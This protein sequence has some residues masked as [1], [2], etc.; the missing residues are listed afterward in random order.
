VKSQGKDTETIAAISTPP[1][2]GAIAVVRVSGERALDIARTLFLPASGENPTTITRGLSVGAIRDPLRERTLD[3]AVMLVFTAPASYTGEDMVEFHC[4][5]GR[6]TPGLVM[7][8]II[9][10]GCREA[11][12]GEFTLRAYLNGKLD[13][14]QAESVADL[15]ESTNELSQRA[16]VLS[17]EGSL[18]RVID[19]LREEV[20]DLSARIEYMIDFPEEDDR[21]EGPHAEAARVEALLG[22]IDHLLLS[23]ADGEALEEGLLTVIAG[24]TNVGKSSLFNILVERERAIVTPI[25]GT[26]RDAIEAKVEVGEFS[27][28]LVDTAGIGESGDPI[29]KKGME[30]SR[31]YLEGADLILLVLEANRN[32]NADEAEFIERYG[33]RCVAVVNKSDLGITIDLSPL[34]GSVP[35]VVISC[36]GRTGLGELREALMKEASRLLHLADGGRGLP[37]VVR[38]RHREALMRAKAALERVR[39]GLGSLPLEFVS[40][41]LKEARDALEEL[42]G[43]VTNEEILDK[44]FTRFC[45]GK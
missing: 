33:N 43:R 19:A 15:V 20:L 14:L 4:H 24:A 2:K 1:G 30:F 42:T 32:L 26:T 44:I 12:R 38:A 7:R 28:R 13:L 3:T 8:S 36:L 6:V 41:E 45:V 27:F 10:A 11:E 37:L 18:T 34:T 39:E 22:R 23:A 17:L 40:L 31:R 25:P 16:A 21:L 29:E 5:G 35:T 9:E